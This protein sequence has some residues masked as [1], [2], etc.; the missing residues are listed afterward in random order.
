MG[1]F[2]GPNQCWLIDVSP[3]APVPVAWVSVSVAAVASPRNSVTLRVH[4]P[5]TTLWACHSTRYH[6]LRLRLVVDATVVPAM[7]RID[8]F[9]VVP[10]R[11]LYRLAVALVGVN[12]RQIDM[13]AVGALVKKK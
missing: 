1:V 8:S 5:D 2:A 12:P 6:V 11:T 7:T 4:V 3:A 10:T 9:D 13:I